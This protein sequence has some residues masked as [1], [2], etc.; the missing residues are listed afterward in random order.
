MVDVSGKW[1]IDGIDLFDIFKV[2]VERGGADFLKFPPK[3]SSIEHDWQDAN[4]RDVDL[5][6]IFFDQREGV[7]HLGIIA[8]DTED[9]FEKQRS[10]IA[11]FAQ[12]GLRRF[13]LA[14]HGQ[15]SYFIYYK[16][17]SSYNTIKGLTGEDTG[18]FA[19]RFTVNV[20]EPEPQIDPQDVFW[21]TGDGRYVIT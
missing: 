9:F 8:T 7:L 11:L 1:F 20:V 2:F 19:Y 21:V 5:S 12:P 14:A 13:T 18:L 16:E 6:R 4:G 10:F 15:R 3:K 17:C